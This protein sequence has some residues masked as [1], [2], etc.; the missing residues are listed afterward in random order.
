MLTGPYVP[1]LAAGSSVLPQ[2]SMPVVAGRG[3]LLLGSHPRTFT[4]SQTVCAPVLSV[5]GCDE[6]SLMIIEVSRQTPRFV[7]EVKWMG[8]RPTAGKEPQS[9]DVKDLLEALK[10]TLAKAKTDVTIE[11]PGS[12]EE[13]NT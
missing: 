9:D 11:G 8:N 7:T 2:A 1:A 13:G 4:A 10:R 6:T 3:S 12:D 5:S